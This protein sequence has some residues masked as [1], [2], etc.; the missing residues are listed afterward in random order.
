[1]NSLSILAQTE[2]QRANEKL[3]GLGLGNTELIPTIGNII[4]ILLGLV[5]VV[6]VIM[7]IIGGFKYTVSGGN[8]KSVEAAKNQIMYAVI[9]IVITLLAAGIVQFV[10]SQLNNATK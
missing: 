9:G 4:T 3:T 6:A 1:V 2:A 5:G 10:L 8:D 7:L